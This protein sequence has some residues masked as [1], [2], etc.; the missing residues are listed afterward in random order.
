[1]MPE[2]FLKLDYLNHIKPNLEVCSF[3]KVKEVITTTRQCLNVVTDI[4]IPPQTVSEGMADPELN[5]EP[6]EGFIL[7]HH[8]HHS[9]SPTP[10]HEDTKTI[11]KRTKENRKG[12]TYGLITSHK[13]NFTLRAGISYE[14]N[15]AIFDNCEM[16]LYNKDAELSDFEYKH[17]NI[18]LSLMDITLSDADKA[19]LDA[20]YARN[21]KT[22]VYT[23]KTHTAISL[24]RY[25]NSEEYTKQIALLDAN[26][27]AGKLGIK[28]GKPKK[29]EALLVDSLDPEWDDLLE[30]TPIVEETIGIC[31]SCRLEDTLTRGYL[32][33]ML[34]DDCNAALGVYEY[35]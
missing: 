22:H 1:M 4:I 13:K 20:E 34:C 14:G 27:K 7:W 25:W 29:K 23:P 18:L 19:F 15:Y 3:L 28:R 21:V 12:M 8:S 5:W 24:T 30:D 31:E 10:S 26:V 9:M 16:Y 6:P 2:V 17:W 11:E 35:E 33:Y 32:N